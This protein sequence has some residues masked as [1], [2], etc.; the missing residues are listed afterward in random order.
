MLLLT[1]YR[2]FGVLD[3]FECGLTLADRIFGLAPQLYIY[4]YIDNY[5]N[6]MCPANASDVFNGSVGCIKLL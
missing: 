5:M 6:V 4:K 2:D 3:A 1:L